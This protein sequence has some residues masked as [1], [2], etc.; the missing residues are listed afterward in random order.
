MGLCTYM[1][2][3]NE[4]LKVGAFTLTKVTTN[5]TNVWFFMFLCQ[6]LY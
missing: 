3:M 2:Q 1:T 4:D 5:V 6:N